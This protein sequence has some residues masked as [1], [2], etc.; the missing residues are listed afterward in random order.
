MASS[1]GSFLLLI[2]PVSR[3][4][5]VSG[6]QHPTFTVS[7]ESLHVKGIVNDQRM[8]RVPSG[9]GMMRLYMHPRPPTSESRRKDRGG[10]F[11]KVPSCTRE[12][13]DSV[14]GSR[15]SFL[16]DRHLS[17]QSGEYGGKVSS[18]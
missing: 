15:N 5:R 12:T 6:I 16:S 10:E 8:T 4:F 7:P 18:L 9:M 2:T 3:W 11:D 17:S 13:E 14:G 1:L